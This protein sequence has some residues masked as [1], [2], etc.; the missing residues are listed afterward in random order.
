MHCLLLFVLAL[1]ADPADYLIRGA[2]IYDGTGQP[3]VVGDVAIRGSKIL[4]VGK[5]EGQAAQVIDGRGLIVAPGFIDLHSHSD[6]GDSPREEPPITASETRDNYNYTAQGCTT[7]V[8]GNCGSGPVDVADFFAA[9]DKHGAGT[10]VV[11][12][13]PH[14]AIR[15]RVFGAADRPPTADELA[16]MQ[17]LVHRGMQ[18]GA[19]G[20]ST[21]LWYPPGSY[22]DVAEVV[23]LAQVVNRYGG[24]YAS[25]IRNEADSLMDA[26]NEAI[27][28]GEQ[29]GCPVQISHIKCST[30][31]A[32]GRMNE[33][34]QLIEAAHKRGVKVT[35]DQ[36]PYTASQT[37]L[38][39]YLIPQKFSDGGDQELLERM[40]DAE[41][42]KI[43]RAAI[44]ERMDIYGGPQSFQI[45]V[46][47][48]QPELNGKTLDEIAKILKKDPVDAAV[49]LIRE[50]EVTARTIAFAMRQDDMLLAMQKD[51]VSTASDGRAAVPS[52]RRPHPRYFGT[53]ARKI[54]HFALAENAI[55]LS[56]AIR[57]CS[58]LPADILGFQDR[59]YLKP[60]YFA[61]L[62]VLDPKEYRDQA[63][64]AEPNRYATGARWVFV[65]GQPVIADGKKTEALPGRALRLSAKSE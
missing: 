19:W 22:A 42:G 30:K 56:H 14:A 46:Y 27:T 40:G 61:D 26:I 62:V 15:K 20:M 43:I 45:S 60:D 35:A 64:F 54:G 24:I 44:A 8:T 32:W 2:T 37:R 33:V 65:N 41:E 53:F 59:G 47:L 7:V 25:H 17:A 9:I 52:A 34:C 58:G 50:S 31:A 36:Y 5:Y 49:H 3:G 63:T 48:P 1:S 57:S 10:N 6:L 29:S 23:A 4:A 39:S 16:K 28:I 38:A 13:L 21:G 11:H 55:S 51:Y 18:D 12:L